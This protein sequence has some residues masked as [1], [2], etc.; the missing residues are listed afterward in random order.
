[1]AGALCYALGL[2]TGIVFLVLAPYNRNPAVR[3]HAFQSIFL[4]IA[5]IGLW[6]VLG[7]L[8]SMASIFALLLVPLYGV[9]GLAGLAGWLFLMYRAYNNQP[10]V[11]PVVGPLAQQQAQA[12]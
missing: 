8:T 1:M 5:W 12:G 10:L 4:N 7:T 2:I 3:F 6:I 9:L 11:V